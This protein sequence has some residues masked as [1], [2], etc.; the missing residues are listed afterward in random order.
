MFFPQAY[1]ESKRS[2]WDNSS[3]FRTDYSGNDFSK[4]DYDYSNDFFGSYLHDTSLILPERLIG[5]RAWSHYARIDHYTF[6]P[7]TMF[8][9]QRNYRSAIVNTNTLGFRAQELSDV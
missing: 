6:F 7:Y 2:P 9:F 4:E 3:A 1:L 5:P 8:H